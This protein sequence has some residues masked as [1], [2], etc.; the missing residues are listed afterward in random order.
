MIQSWKNQTS[1]QRISEQNLQAFNASFRYQ[2]M[3][4]FGTQNQ[5]IKV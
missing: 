2:A 4:T 5:R 3:D 1:D